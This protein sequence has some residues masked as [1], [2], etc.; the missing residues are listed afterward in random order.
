MKF[1][2]MDDINFED[3]T[4]FLRADL[5]VPMDKG[6]ITDTTRVDFVL[7]TINE[8]IE[9]GGK[10]I[11]ASHLGRPNGEKNPELSLQP[12]ADYIKAKIEN[13]KF[14]EDCVGEKV[15]AAVANLKKGEVL[16]LEN[17]RFYKEEKENDPIFSRRLAEFADVYINDAFSAAHRSHASIEGITH[18]VEEKAAGR[19]M[20]KEITNLEKALNQPEKPVL[21]IIGGFKVSTKIGVLE[22]LIQKVDMLFI[23]GAM[24]CT[25]LKAKGYEIGKSF[26]EDDMIPIANKIMQKAKAQNTELIISS[27]VVIAEKME[28]DIETETVDVENIPTNKEVFDIGLKT[29]EK[30]KV[31]IEKAKTII[32]N[33]P[34]GAF[35]VPPFDEGSKVIAKLIAEKTKK[36]GILSVAGGGD[37]VSCLKKAGVIDGFSYISTAGGAFLEFAEGKE[38]PGIKAL[39]I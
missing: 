17:L 27:D 32:W 12:V 15:E 21:G 28:N 29:I 5:N 35:E 24:A 19:L 6:T 4:A 2:T 16:I 1:K 18:Y 26:A 11:A 25:F 33:G 7:P 36:D 20:E 22:N 3:K 37:T 23:G 13:V 31:L 34:V 9:K 10:V 39:Y 8:I 14:V 30:A 38:L